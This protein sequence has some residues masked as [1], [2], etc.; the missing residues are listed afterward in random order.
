M[1]KTKIFG[2]GSIGNHL[3]Q[4][5]RRMGWSV[6]ICDIDTEA[7]ERTKNNIYPSRYGEWDNEIGLYSCS[8]VP[9][10]GYDLVVI[11]TP[12]D[13][14][15]SLARAA[16][17]EGAKA[18]LVE[19]PLCT[20]D[21]V[22]AQELF[23]EAKKKN[24]IVFIGYDHAISKSAVCMAKLLEDEKV[25]KVQ[26]IDVEF[27][28][29]WGGI[30]V[31]HPWL[32]GPS[33][34]YLGFW[35]RGGGAC[36]EHS[37]AINLFQMF[38]N[39]AKVGRIIEVNANMEYIKDSKVDYDSLCLMQIKTE[40]GMI[41]RVVQDVITQPTRKWAR[42][43]SNNGFVEW[44]CGNKPGVDTVIY[45]RNNEKV[46]T[47]E[48]SKTRPDDFYEEMKHIELA[49]KNKDMYD[50][51][52]ISLEKGLDTALVIAAAHLSAKNN[53]TVLIDYS[54]GY[55]NDALSLLKR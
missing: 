2:A 39:A 7:I 52:P 37:H 24:C 16:V 26:T 13:S 21:L 9:V 14:H 30:F 20:P 41:G 1:F 28:E 33:D 17:K 25:G 15:M 22:G 46:N 48:I 53:R 47:K 5:S 36:G 51:S 23:N 29:Y 50:K 11:G 19:K 43:Q 10:G 6:D 4:A 31:A 54:Q 8:D 40:N 35:A 34:T 38:A 44:Y 3:A 32:D 55:T 49:I 45:G 27:R 18:V 42:V 12:P